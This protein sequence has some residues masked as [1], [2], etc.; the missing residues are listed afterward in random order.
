MVAAAHHHGDTGLVNSLNLLSHCNNLGLPTNGMRLN[1]P[2]SSAHD[3]RINSP[4]ESSSGISRIPL[5]AQY[6]FFIHVWSFYQSNNVLKVRETL[7][8]HR[9]HHRAILSTVAPLI[10]QQQTLIVKRKRRDPFDHRILNPLPEWRMIT[11]SIYQLVTYR[12][13]PRTIT[14]TLKIW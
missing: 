11:K 7:T 2:L 8:F 13:H 1:S 4:G 6:F 14:T 9:V 10:Y 12:N 3:L 5:R